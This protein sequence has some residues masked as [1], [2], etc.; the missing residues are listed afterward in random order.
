MSPK[1]RK[2]S[3]VAGIAFAV[4]F[5]WWFFR[6]P[7]PDIAGLKRPQLVLMD[8]AGAANAKPGV[9]PRT[10]PGRNP[11]VSRPAVNRRQ[12]NRPPVG[13]TGRA[14][15]LNGAVNRPSL[16]PGTNG[17]LAQ[18]GEAGDWRARRR[19]MIEAR[20]QRLHELNQG[21]QGQGE[22]E[23]NEVVPGAQEGD[24]QDLGA[25]GEGIPPEAAQPDA[26]QADGGEQPQAGGEGIE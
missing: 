21:A 3:L 6:M 13:R 26:G 14:S 24:E 25:E 10:V 15:S 11:A 9:Q 22:G 8:A 19:E 18:P 1:M 4:L 17:E 16:D 5:G 23:D 7:A 2:L 20:R 12:V